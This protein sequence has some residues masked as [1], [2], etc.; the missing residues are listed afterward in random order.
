MNHLISAAS[1]NHKEVPIIHTYFTELEQVEYL[2]IGVWNMTVWLV[3]LT[4]LQNF[5]VLPTVFM[6]HGHIWNHQSVHFEQDIPV[7]SGRRDGTYCDFCRLTFQW[8]ALIPVAEHH[9]LSVLTQ[10]IQ[11]FSTFCSCAASVLIL[12][13]LIWLLKS[14]QLSLSELIP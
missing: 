13:L 1:S 6:L 3:T 2:N 7:N 12:L 5:R 10:Q 11:F 4:W 8:Q 14:Q 9:W